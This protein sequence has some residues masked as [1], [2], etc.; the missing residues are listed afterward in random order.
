MNSFPNQAFEPVKSFLDF[1]KKISLKYGDKTAYKYFDGN[2]NIAEMSY[3]EF[4]KQN[5]A[6]SAAFEEMGLKGKRI[7][8][9]GESCTEWVTAYIATLCIGSVAVPLDK[10]LDINELF[11]FLS[12]SQANAI[13]FTKS[14]CSKFKE[15]ILSDT[16]DML[17]FPIA[18]DE[19]EILSCKNVIMFSEL[20]SVGENK[21]KNGYATTEC[22]ASDE[23]REMLFTSGTTGTSKCVMLS[24]K[25]VI[26]CVNSAGATV[27][28]NSEDVIVS[29]L[30]LHH[31]YEL[32][33]MI[34]A[35][36]LGLTVCINDSLKY[37]LRNFKLFR[38][39]GLILVPLFVNTMYKKIMDEAKKTGQLN[40]LKLGMFASSALLKVGIDKREKIFA[41]VLQ[42]F[43]SRLNKIVC[44]GAA[45]NPEYADA[46][47]KFGVNIYEGYGITECSPLIS[48][49]PFKN[50]KRGSVGP[51]V[52]SC[53]AKI[54]G[55][56]KN[57]KGFTEGEI[58]VKGE[59]VMLGYYENQQATDE[60]FTQDGYFKTGDIGYMDN[61]GYIYITGR[62]KTV[63]VLENG[64]NV[65]PEEIEEYL[66]S[67]QTIAESV[68]VGRHDGESVVLTA[69]IYPAFDKFEKGTDINVI[70]DNIKASINAM[71]K[72][73][74]SFK[75]IRNIELRQNEFEKTT[76]R[77]IKRYLIK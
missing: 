49:N 42:A 32:A 67:I 33:I 2:K 50:P 56:E 65:F 46:F 34:T 14:F 24:E 74:P 64:K 15:K 1:N 75:Q 58:L 66:S 29:V 10:E 28:F 21:I 20:L 52:P 53:S 37:V 72:K 45:L 19:E 70:G 8:I 69:I 68:V 9:V 55:T 12:I 23:M 43:G 48:V 18:C 44:G 16:G 54:D 63:I 38:P 36:S 57:S 76:S 17:Y 30:P 13:V 6:I 35:L 40:K 59:N 3:K 26:S 11:K 41:G 73:L 25:N 71:N 4:S 5:A 27:D 39:T 62:K 60:A 61:D 7:A 77:K 31:T 47:K 22:E 51:T